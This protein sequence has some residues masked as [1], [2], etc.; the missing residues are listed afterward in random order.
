MA[1]RD[2]TDAMRPKHMTFSNSQV[3]LIGSLID[4]LDIGVNYLQN[5]SL[6]GAKL[7]P[8]DAT[9]SLSPTFLALV[10]LLLGFI[11]NVKLEV[12]K[13][14]KTPLSYDLHFMLMSKEDDIYIDEIDPS[15]VMWCIEASDC[16]A[17]L[18]SCSLIWNSSNVKSS[19]T[20]YMF[21]PWLGVTLR[22][23]IL[24]QLP[25]VSALVY[26]M[27][28]ID[29]QHVNLMFLTGFSFLFLLQARILL[30]IIRALRARWQRRALSGDER[31]VQ[32]ETLWSNEEEDVPSV[33]MRNFL[34]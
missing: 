27:A 21:L 1:N 11:A 18:I 2:S 34:Y 14:D 30:E 15:H 8:S 32:V 25:T 6:R 17:L 5:R 7:R 29:S 26:T 10:C 4:Y 20:E 33:E 16:A 24:R 12:V 28:I 23:L 31:R 13:F 3:P 22:G 9:P 19:F